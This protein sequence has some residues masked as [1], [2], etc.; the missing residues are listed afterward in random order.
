MI[1]SVEGL[2][3]RLTLSASV[4]GFAP[5]H[6][7]TANAVRDVRMLNVPG[8]G[9]ASE[10]E[11]SDDSGG[12]GSQQQTS[13]V[14]PDVAN[15]GAPLPARPSVRITPVIP[16]QGLVLPRMVS[17]PTPGQQTIASTQTG[18]TRLI[19][20]NAEA[21]ISFEAPVRLARGGTLSSRL[22]GAIGRLADGVKHAPIVLSQSTA[23][24]P[25][26]TP[27]TGRRSPSDSTPAARKRRAKQSG[28][29]PELARIRFDWR[30]P[31]QPWTQWELLPNSVT[32]ACDRSLGSS[33]RFGFESS[34][35]ASPSRRS[36]GSAERRRRIRLKFR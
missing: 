13:A 27:G 7:E 19:A 34:G 18:A 21:V 35:L 3:T 22:T 16:G 31:L 6:V 24:T 26:R 20:V 14:E 2:E 30:P 23:T 28:P 10:S 36:G 8:E 12:A 25:K 15:G 11:E 33:G 29:I 32:V 1:A 5:H 9:A 17:R 4:V